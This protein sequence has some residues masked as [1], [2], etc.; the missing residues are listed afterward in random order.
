VF[1]AI[2]QL[3]KE[4]PELK[5]VLSVSATKEELPSYMKRYAK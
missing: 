5:L 1:K 2:K 4:Y 3:Q